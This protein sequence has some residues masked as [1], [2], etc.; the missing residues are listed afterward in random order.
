MKISKKRKITGCILLGLA[1]LCEILTWTDIFLLK[2]YQITYRIPWLR[3]LLAALAFALLAAG[4]LVFYWVS[5]RPWRNMWILFAG[6]GL[7]TF[8]LGGFFTDDLKIQVSYEL[9]SSFDDPKTITWRDPVHDTTMI[10]HPY[11]HFFVKQQPFPKDP[12]LNEE[13][14]SLDEERLDA[15]SEIVCQMQQLLAADPTLETLESTISGSFR[16]AGSYSDRNWLIKNSLERYALSRRTDGADRYIQLETVKITAG[17]DSDFLAQVTF[18]EQYTVPAVNGQPLSAEDTSVCLNF[19]IMQGQECYAVY[20]FT[21]EQ[22][23]MY[24]LEM[25]AEPETLSFSENDMYHIFMPGDY[26]AAGFSALEYDPRNAV[27]ILFAS[28]FQSAYPEA[29]FLTDNPQIGYW[30]GGQQHLLFDGMTNDR[31]YLR[32]WHYDGASGYPVTIS[33]YLM[34]LGSNEVIQNTP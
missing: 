14:S 10:W 34:P 29:V 19:R 4:C 7:T 3:S 25:I 30:L 20:P 16:I 12:V 13:I 5:E 6:A 21:E 23:G 1:F 26:I 32:F 18:T 28:H 17:I 15:D 2:Y 9:S 31:Q 8:I 27:Q 33:Y 11:K 24:S 22:N